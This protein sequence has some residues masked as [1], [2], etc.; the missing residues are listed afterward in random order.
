MWTFSFSKSRL[1]DFFEG[2]S[3]GLGT[4][5][6]CQGILKLQ[7]LGVI[8]LWFVSLV[9]L[10]MLLLLASSLGQSMTVVYGVSLGLCSWPCTSSRFPIRARFVD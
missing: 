8:A 7:S 10:T 1:I 5:Q 3:D 6:T 2:T 9:W 4:R